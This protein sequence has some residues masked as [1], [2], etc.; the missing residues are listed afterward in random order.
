MI[1]QSSITKKFIMAF[2]GIFLV[3]FLLVHLGI[4][5][6]IL[7]IH[8]N[9]QEIF[10]Q[11]VKFMTSNLVVK[12]FEV[13]LF[14][15]FII[16]MAYGV[17]LQVQNWMAR[18]RRYKKGGWS[19]TSFFSKFMIHTGIIV[20]IFLVIHFINFYFVKL[21]WTAAPSGQAPVRG[22]HDF[23]PMAV[24]L[25]SN[26]PYA[27]L[28]I[29]LIILLGFH[30]SHAFQ[31]AFQSLGLNHSKYSPIIRWIGYLYSIIVPLGFICIPL[32]FLVF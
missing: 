30:L 13:V 10:G 8:V 3:L 26:T 21:G 17:I 25:F 22:D 19:Q 23:Y 27:I 16:H 15:T 6:F 32:Y 5:L 9:H 1:K 14:S 4:N 7:P 11:A 31:S 18:P 29:V 28:Y 20:L 12:V 24:N 2:A